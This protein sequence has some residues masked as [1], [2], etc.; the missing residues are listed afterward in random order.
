MNR[1]LWIS[2]YSNKV[3]GYRMCI[4]CG[5]FNDMRLGIIHMHG[6]RSGFTS[7]EIIEPEPPPLRFFRE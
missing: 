1:W 3:L 2:N 7:I 4:E 5:C 6:A